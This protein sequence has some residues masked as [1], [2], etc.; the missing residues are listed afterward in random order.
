[1]SIHFEQLYDLLLLGFDVSIKFPESQ[2]H[3]F[4]GVAVVMIGG[5]VGEQFQQQPVLFAEEV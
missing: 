4:F 5:S 2:P 3:W 1:V